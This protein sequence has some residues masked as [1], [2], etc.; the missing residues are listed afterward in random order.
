MIRSLCVIPARYG[1]TRLPAKP[2]ALIGPKPLVR[3]VWER[4]RESRAFDRIVV[5]TDDERIA[6]VVRGFGGEARLTSPRLASGTDRVAAVARTLPA[7][8]VTNLQSDEPFIAPRALAA[9]VRAMRRDPRCPL[10]TLARRTPWRAIAANPHAV[11]VVTD[12]RGRAV[13]FSRAPVPF[14]WTGRGDLLQHVGV[15]CY[16]RAFLLRFARMRRSALERRERLE[17]LRVL[18]YG[19][20]PRVVVAVT[21]ALSVDTRHDLLRAHEWLNRRAGSRGRA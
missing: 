15:Y 3:H 2:L 17:Q 1:S 20:R 13:Y 11:K 5:A 16:R 18:E 10:G 14:D 21:P 6:R 19:I 4:A 12:A 7:S 8:L 9:L